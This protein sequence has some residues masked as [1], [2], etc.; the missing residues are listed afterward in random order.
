MTNYIALTD[1]GLVRQK[2][3]DSIRV[4]ENS[5]G[6][7]IY[8]LADGMGG[9]N[10]G[11]V[12]SQMVCKIIGD[13]FEKI[14][15]NTDYKK[16][17]K[18]TIYEANREVYKNSLLNIE[19]NNMGT[20]LSVIIHAGKRMYTGHVGDSR[21]YYI[22]DEGIRQLTKDHTLV[23]AMLDAKTLT[24][25]EAES[26]KFKNVILQALGTTKAIK[27]DQAEIKVP[28]KFKF[29]ICSDGLTGKVT[30]KEIFS[31]MHEEKKLESR[32]TDLISLAN[33]K[34]G[35]DNVSVIGIERD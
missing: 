34:D 20:T 29:I 10:A 18:E 13:A 12:A 11:E 9:H 33:E 7:K 19:Y 4:V 2:N 16:F 27:L 6:H 22:N 14:I 31:I 30:N 8:I 32:V 1:V 15:E 3:E 24:E 23:Q 25:E 28:Q 26:S 21:I 5:F 17:L 35:S